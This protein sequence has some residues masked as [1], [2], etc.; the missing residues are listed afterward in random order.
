MLDGSHDE[1]S[2]PHCLFGP[3]ILRRPPVFLTGRAAPSLVNNRK[4]FKLYQQFLQLLKDL[5]L[6]DHPTY[7]I[8]GKEGIGDAPI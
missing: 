6:W 1:P 7:L 3:C 4:R 5:G 8:P 2:C